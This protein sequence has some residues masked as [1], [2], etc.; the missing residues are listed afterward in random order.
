MVVTRVLRLDDSNFSLSRRLCICENMSC[1]VGLMILFLQFLLCWLKDRVEMHINLFPGSLLRFLFQW[2]LSRSKE[3][4]VDTLRFFTLVEVNAETF[5][6]LVNIFSLG[7]SGFQGSSN[8]NKTIH[9]LQI[10]LPFW[11]HIWPP[12]WIVGLKLTYQLGTN[13]NQPSKINTYLKSLF[14]LKQTALTNTKH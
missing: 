12:F 8:S 2:V 5:C 14:F 11:T 3:S 13:T 1:D 4:S 7:W 9:K 6:P 10:W